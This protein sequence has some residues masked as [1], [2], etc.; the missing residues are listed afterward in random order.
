MNDTRYQIKEVKIDELQSQMV[1]QQYIGLPTSYQSLTAQTCKWLQV[2]FKNCTFEID[3][4]GEKTQINSSEILESDHVHKILNFPKKLQKL[5]RVHPK[6]LEELSYRGFQRFQVRIANSPVSEEQQKRTIDV[7]ESNKFI[8]LVKESAMLRVQA[9]KAVESLFDDARRGISSTKEIEHYVDKMTE[10]SS[11]DALSAIVS[12][13]QSDQT[14]AHCIDVGVIFNT[15]YSGLIKKKKVIN[16]FKDHKETT[17]AAILHDFGK[18]KIPK[19]ILESTARFNRDSKEMKLM[20]S[21]PELGA[22][23]LEKMG[24][25]DT[26]INMAHFHHVKEDS[27]LR[28]SYPVADSNP[29]IMETKL[30]GI[31]DVYQ[32]L[33]G[34]REY[35]KSWAPSAAMRYL[36]ALSGIEF[37]LDI[38]DSFL[39]MMGTYPKGSL[40][41]LNDGTTGFIISVPENDLTRP[42]VVLTKNKKGQLLKNNQFVDLEIEKDIE[43]IDSLDSFEVF[44]DQALEIFQNLNVVI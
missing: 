7:E 21:H 43:I 37:N 6:L 31:I 19:D 14:Y 9:T 28:T 40:V 26:M 10:K 13:K 44:G 1:I 3:R 27:G 36:D 15:V 29:I 35:K 16:K 25:S 41:L 12:L 39:A 24:M 22:E 38:W 42:Q 20:M 2:N 4:K 8:G 23:L 33:V 17:L 18:S 32:A 5:T 11:T 34:K 30:L